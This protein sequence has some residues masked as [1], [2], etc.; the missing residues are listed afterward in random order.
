MPVDTAGARVVR[1]ALT[2]ALRDPARVVELAPVELDLLL[3]VARRC[4]LLGRLAS[5]LQPLRLMQSL[6]PMAV[7]QL[8]SALIAAEARSRV[9]RWEL[10]RVAWALEGMEDVPVVALKGSAYVL[11]GLPNAAGRLFAD[12][13]LLV[14]EP[15]LPAVE[16]RLLRRGWQAK[17]LTP[18]D[19]RYYR[20]WAHELPP[21]V[22]SERGVELDLHHGIVMRTARLQPA[23]QLL[24]EAARAVPGSRYKVLAPVDMVLHAMVH[25][26]YGSEMDDALRDLVDIDDM[27]RH[28]A[29]TEPG[30]W[31]QF[32]PRA[33]SLGLS[34]PAYYGLRYASHL[35]GT[36]TSANVQQASTAAGAPYGVRWIMDHIVPLSLLPRHPDRSHAPADLARAI[37]YARSHWVKMSPSKLIPHLARKIW[38]RRRLQSGQ[39]P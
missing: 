17:E 16:E 29:A 6:P 27:L 14:P 4:R 18:Y 20:E 26:F 1:D 23:P 13:D 28:F 34:R 24:I 21:L 5:D 11:A 7:D 25:L 3:R 32:V 31:E 33:E 30:F 38:L 22:H 15:D 39:L 19:E 8:Q 12:I 36:P 35:L 2:I 9:A 10:N 37:S